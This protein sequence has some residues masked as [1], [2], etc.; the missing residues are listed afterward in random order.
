MDTILRDEEEIMEKKNPSVFHF[1]A[2]RA[3]YLLL[4]YKIIHII[5]K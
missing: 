5:E 3:K 2:E 4:L 1:Q